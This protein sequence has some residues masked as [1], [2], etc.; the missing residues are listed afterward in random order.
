MTSTLERLRARLRGQPSSAAASGTASVHQQNQQGS[1][2]R[3]SLGASPSP[4]SESGVAPNAT[5]DPSGTLLFRLVQRLSSKDSDEARDSAPTQKDI[6]SDGQILRHH[7]AA[8]ALTENELGSCWHLLASRPS[9]P[10]SL[11]LSFM[12]ACIVHHE[13]HLGPILRTEFY[14]CLA[15]EQLWGSKDLQSRIAI[16]SLLTKEGR[17]VRGFESDIGS[18][19]LTWLR[20]MPG[21]QRQDSNKQKTRQ[22]SMEEFPIAQLLSLTT[23]ILKFSFLHLSEDQAVGILQ[24]CTQMFEGSIM[25]ET[26]Q[27]SCLGVF[28]A[29]VRYGSV[30]VPSL[31]SVLK[32][33]CILLY[34]T[35]QTSSEKYVTTITGS[36]AF[37]I[38]KNLLKSHRSRAAVGQLCTLL[39]KPRD[40]KNATSDDER[41][42]LGAVRALWQ[43]HWG[44]ETGQK[45]DSLST[46]RSLLLS[47]LAAVNNPPRLEMAGEVSLGLV[48]FLHNIP[49]DSLSLLEWDLIVQIV[50]GWASLVKVMKDSS[51]EWTD[52]T[53]LDVL[54]TALSG[55]ETADGFFIRFN[56]LLV[57]ICFQCDTLLM[58]TQGKALDALRVLARQ[59]DVQGVLFLIAKTEGA[60]PLTDLFFDIAERMPTSHQD[61]LVAISTKLEVCSDFE[62]VLEK[63]VSYLPP[64]QDEVS[65]S[66]LMALCLRYPSKHLVDC[67]AQI[68]ETHSNEAIVMLAMKGLIKAWDTVAAKSAYLLKSTNIH[69]ERDLCSHFLAFV[70]KQNLSVSARLYLVRFLLHIRALANSVQ[71]MDL[72]TLQNRNCSSLLI[73]ANPEMPEKALLGVYPVSDYIS[74][75]TQFMTLETNWEMYTLVLGHLLAQ[76]ENVPLFESQAS[77][78]ALVPLAISVIELLMRES[79][80]AQ[81]RNL[82]ATFKS[83]DLY[84]HLFR[85]LSCLLQTHKHVF[86]RKVS[87]DAVLCFLSGLSRPTISRFCM[88]SLTLCL[89]EH[90]QSMIRHLPTVITKLS[91]MTSFML[92]IQNLEFLSHLGR[93]P[94]LHVNLTADDYRRVFGI[95]LQYI[96]GVSSSSPQNSY[97]FH[98]AYHVMSLWFVLLPLGERRIYVSFISKQL[99]G[100]GIDENIEIVLDMLALYSF[101]DCEPRA[102][103]QMARIGGKTWIQGNVVMTIQT[104]TEFSGWSE[105]MIRRPSGTVVFWSRLE[106]AIVARPR[107]EASAPL[108]YALVEGRELRS[109][110][111]EMGKTHTRSISTGSFMIPDAAEVN[112]KRFGSLIASSD[113]MDTPR[114]A[115]SMSASSNSPPAATRNSP[116]VRSS[117]F[118][119]LRS[120]SR[121]SPIDPSFLLCQMT[122]IPK[123]LATD[124]TSLPILL[125]SDDATN[126]ALSVLDRTPVIDLHTVGVLYVG[127]G[128]RTESEIL[129]NKSGSRDYGTFLASL[130]S[131]FQLDKSPNIYFGGLDTSSDAMDGQYGLAHVERLAQCV[132]HVPTLM[133]S[134]DTDPL[135]TFKKR[136]IGNDYVNIIWNESGSAYQLSTLE[137]QFNFMAIVIEPSEAGFRVSVQV[138]PELPQVSLCTEHA[139]IVSASALGPLVRTLAIH[140][141][142]IS[143]IWGDRFVKAANAR[144]SQ[145]HRIRERAMDQRDRQ[146]TDV[147][148]FSHYT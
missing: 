140:L 67:L 65:S 118:Q 43:L 76:L 84:F 93:L 126:R 138:K 103:T 14:D 64:L 92:G 98:L 143:Q 86:P 18:C 37:G 123:L 69:L 78:A 133:P 11:L 25:G 119:N 134:R 111:N 101:A 91:Q 17:D 40:L 28:D 83:S 58:S 137:G 62:K 144:L 53:K 51:I 147:L 132:F 108:A 120:L 10:R 1:P 81:L 77:K 24:V 107:V 56:W 125:P 16:L 26:L 110:A 22:N 99:L 127:P 66:K 49:M 145:I 15:N 44:S 13:S 105:V 32:T 114:R 82:P 102:P 72:E 27:G 79:V 115:R 7:L 6:T 116:P 71:Y 3:S 109:S 42:L 63:L 95:A 129:T 21:S 87:D 68:V 52:V 57:R 20:P 60:A 70:N 131:W 36:T 121:E 97:I 35:P 112:Q 117:S 19:L 124:T 39:Q 85:L 141:D 23:N 9:P 34:E 41:V 4:L 142:T 90:P 45:L 8:S 148:D 104:S 128:Q 54:N 96:R 46:S 73:E 88:H 59:M 47:S 80:G 33:L 5:E 135:A 29:A 75:L 139:S 74:Q 50:T 136:H 130:G 12:D 31:G 89:Y 61:C 122:G 48:R 106:N 30:P 146:E 100:C 38:L 2:S 94:N 113:P 55:Q